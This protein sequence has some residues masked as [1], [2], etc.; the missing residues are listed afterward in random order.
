MPEN[1]FYAFPKHG[2]YNSLGKVCQQIV[3]IVTNFNGIMNYVTIFLSS[4]SYSI[5][6]H[7][8]E[9]IFENSPSAVL[10]ALVPEGPEIFSDFDRFNFNM[11][12]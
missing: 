6:D 8:K 1:I 5:Y 10:V 7:V 9:P 4:S 11:H 12:F 3:I 2:A